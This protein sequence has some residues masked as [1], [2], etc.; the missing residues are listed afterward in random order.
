VNSNAPDPVLLCAEINWTDLQPDLTARNRTGELWNANYTVPNASANAAAV[1]TLVSSNWAADRL[2]SAAVWERAQV[3]AD[4]TL[5]TAPFDPVRRL[6]P[7]PDDWR[8]LG[9]ATNWVAL[10]GQSGVGFGLTSDGT[11][12]TWGLELGKEPVKTLQTRLQM[13]RRRL[14]GNG[15]PPVAVPPYSSEPRPLLK[16]VPTPP[17]Q[18]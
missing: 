9:A 10:W 13:L 14:T 7:L 4:G 5:W 8:Q 11:L 2:Q 15:G 3:R 16:L 18:K 1:L 12:W 6:A 17:N